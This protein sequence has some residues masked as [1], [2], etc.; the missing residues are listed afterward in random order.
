MLILGLQFAMLIVNDPVILI[1]LLVLVGFENIAFNNTRGS[2]SLLRAI[3]PL[4]IF[5]G[6]FSFIFGGP[7]QAFLVVL[8]LL[9]GAFSCSLFFAVTNPSDLTRILEKCKIPTRWA[10]LPSLALTMVPRVAKDAEETLETLA[11]RGEI[12]GFFLKWLP[13]VLAI[14]VA[15]VLYRSEFLAQSLYFRGLAIQK[16]THYRS[17]PFQRKDIFRLFVWLVFLTLMIIVR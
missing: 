17:V 9:V 1:L 6:G 10:L 7:I 14:F 12:S 15:S 2:L 3:I 13:K 16:R 5:L 8:R 11:F 4:L